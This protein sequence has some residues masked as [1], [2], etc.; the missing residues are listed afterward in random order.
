MLRP[1]RN[2]DALQPAVLNSCEQ[3]SLQPLYPFL[4]QPGKLCAGRAQLPRDGGV[5]LRAGLC[6]L[7]ARHI[8]RSSNPKAE[9]SRAEAEE[10]MDEKSLPDLFG[11]WRPSCVSPLRCACLVFDQPTRNGMFTLDWRAR[12]QPFMTNRASAVVLQCSC[13]PNFLNGAEELF[14][15]HGRASVPRPGSHIRPAR[16]TLQ[17]T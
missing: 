9:A 4:V 2:S 8:C 12:L 7:L 10:G 5:V 3:S 1:G 17:G 15:W 14:A 13:W 11:H 6:H 16:C